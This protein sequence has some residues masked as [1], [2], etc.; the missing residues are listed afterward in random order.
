MLLSNKMKYIGIGC[1]ILPSNKVCSV[2]DIVQ[3]FVS[4]G[5]KGV[6]LMQLFY[7]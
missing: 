4:F 1:C 7:L 6:L 2:I 3:E 5:Q